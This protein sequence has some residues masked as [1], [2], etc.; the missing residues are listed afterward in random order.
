MPRPFT[1]TTWQKRQN[2]GA[3]LTIQLLNVT[4]T[5]VGHDGA[6][7]AAD[8]KGQKLSLIASKVETE[9][10]LTRKME[11]NV[12]AEVKFFGAGVDASMGLAAKMS[13]GKSTTNL[14]AKVKVINGVRVAKMPKLLPEAEKLLTQGEP[15]RARF[16]E[17][18]GT[19]YVNGVE[20]GGYLFALLQMNKVTE[21]DVKTIES[22]LKADHGFKISADVKDSLINKLQQW[23]TTVHVV[24]IGGIG[25][26]AAFNDPEKLFE[27]IE[28]FPEQVQGPG[29]AP[30]MFITKGYETLSSPGDSFLFDTEIARETLNILYRKIVQLR[31]DMHDVERILEEGKNIPDWFRQ[32]AN[33]TIQVLSSQINKYRGIVRTCINT[34]FQECEQPMF[35]LSDQDRK[36]LNIAGQ[37]RMRRP[38]SVTNDMVCG[39]NLKTTEI[40]M[41]K[42]VPHYRPLPR[43]EWS[44]LWPKGKEGDKRWREAYERYKSDKLYQAVH[45]KRVDHVQSLLRAGYDPLNLSSYDCWDTRFAADFFSPNLVWSAIFYKRSEK[46]V[47]LLLDSNRYFLPTADLFKPGKRNGRTVLHIAVLRKMSD[48]VLQNI[49]EISGAED[50]DSL[51]RFE[52]SATHYAVKVGLRDADFFK[53]AKHIASSQ[54]NRAS[55][56][57]RQAQR[58]HIR[59]DTE[60]VA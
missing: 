13:R 36:L 32:R 30:I 21:E 5:C 33:E 1:N 45:V 20:T 51:D 42:G 43:S 19:E 56:A 7:Y 39:P 29:G 46:I 17:M 54:N 49:L 4:G 18:C 31:K 55:G 38:D 15:G 10:E 23:G 60:L 44:F 24:R 28:R 48:Q 2:W 11:V 14:L 22:S 9:S 52:L 50:I 25:E 8:T 58:L 35:G 40:T 6:D 26:P 59:G 27:A 3:V 53:L 12:A 34:K 16:R 41:V 57:G 47:R 37:F